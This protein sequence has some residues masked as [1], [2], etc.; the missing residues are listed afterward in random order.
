MSLAGLLL[1]LINIA[2][3]IVV[4]V[5]IGAALAWVAQMLQW[6]IPWNIQR[7]YLALVLLVALYM[8]VALLFGLPVVHVIG[9]MG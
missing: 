7:L 1:G 3:V 6:P 5:L 2:L 8:V 9:R 4:L